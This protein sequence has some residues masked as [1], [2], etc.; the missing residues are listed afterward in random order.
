MLWIH[1]SNA[2]RFEQSIRDIARRVQLTGSDGPGT[3]ILQLFQAWLWDVRSGRWLIILDNAD[4]ASF[5]VD[6]PAVDARIT[7]FECLPVCGHG[8]VLITTRSKS[9]ALQ[10]AEEG[11]IIAVKPMEE[12]DAITLLQKKLGESSYTD[13]LKAL[14]TTLE[15]MPLAITQAA[16]Y[17]KRR[18]KRSSPQQYL[19]EL[20]KSDESKTSLLDCDKG[21]LRRD[22]TAKNSIFLTWQISFQ[23]ISNVKP[24]AADLL[25][26]MSLCDR[27]AIPEILIRD[28]KGEQ[29]SPDDG[30]ED[31]VEVLSG[32]SFI[33]TSTDPSTFKMHRLVQLAT[34]KWKEARGEVNRQVEEFVAKLYNAFP[35]SDHK[36]WSTCSILFPHAK[37]ALNAI[38]ASERGRLQ[39][40]A[41][42]S[43]AAEYASVKGGA[44]L[45][46]QAIDMGERCWEMRKAKLG[47]DHPHTLTS[48]SKLAGYYDRLGDSGRAAEMEERCWEITKMKLG[49]D[50]PHTLA[51]M[52]NLAGYYGRLGDSGRAAEMGERC[53]E[54]RKAKLGEDHPDTL[55]SMSN[56]AWYYDRLG[57]SSRAAEMEERCREMRKVKL[58]EDHPDMLTSMSNLADYYER[59][60]DSGRAAEIGERCWEMRKAKLGEDHPDTLTSISKLAGYYDRLGD[61]GRAAEIGERCREMR[62][63]KLGEDHPD[64]LTSISKLAG[65][66]DR[67]GDSGRAAEMG[68]RC[69]EITKMKLGEDHPHTLATMSNLAGYYGRLGD[70]GR[71]AEMGERCWEITK[72]KLGEDHPDTLTSMNNLAWYYDR[73]GDSGRAAE[74]GERCWEMRKAKLGED[75]P[76]TLTSMSN[77][78]GY[79]DRLGDSGR[80]AEMGERCWEM[81]K[82]KLGE[83]HPHTLTSMSKLAGYY[84]RLGDSGR[85]AEMGERCWEMRKARN[86]KLR[87]TSAIRPQQ[88]HC[89]TSIR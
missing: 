51:T 11:D 86:A 1:A 67:L 41:V 34:R 49:E 44:L 57:D 6:S 5:L 2:V 59:L 65:Y 20:R 39:W 22:R 17:I 70:S 60:G 46:S 85:A 54:M 66:Y 88:E 71:A 25:S 84:D 83:D 36:N 35:S 48:I 77:L 73:L 31:D 12:E 3:D 33:S 43:R 19:T 63:A 64:M 47:E 40:A 10:L 81:R 37:S 58:G 52:S 27:Q 78:A 42:I 89:H 87:N 61:S 4:D 69:W 79:Y 14:A 24:S 62:K 74:M 72:M 29:S 76:D 75:H 38:P 82:A 7:P 18:G 55:A 80:A 32:F 21:D 30:F 26:L 45:W 56:L 53:W 8:S 28:Q 23:H 50:H 13:D 16:A 15:F 68:E 9:A